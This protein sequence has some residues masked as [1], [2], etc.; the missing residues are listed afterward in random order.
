MGKVERRH[1]HIVDTGLAMLKHTGIEEQFWDY[2]FMTAVYLY[3][4]NPTSILGGISPYEALN[5]RAPEY[6]KLR[7]F[8]SICYPNMRP[9][10][11]NKLGDKSQQC[12]F[13]GYPAN[14]DG[15]ICMNM[16]DGRTILSRDVVFLENDFLSKK[17]L[18]SENTEQLDHSSDDEHEQEI[19]HTAGTETLV[20]SEKIPNNSF[21]IPDI[22]TYVRRKNVT[23][24]AEHPHAVSI[25]EHPIDA[26]D[27]QQAMADNLLNEE[28][29][30]VSSKSSSDEEYHPDESEE[31][32]KVVHIPV[33]R[34]VVKRGNPKYVLSITPTQ[35]IAPK[36]VKLA[37]AD[38][39]WKDAMQQEYDA[40]MRNE[41]WELI[42]KS[43]TDN[44]I[45]NI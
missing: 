27:E 17:D 3:N 39:E 12:V 21:S 45:N 15:Y 18:N 5:H 37:L 29:I 34:G 14:C 10:R 36:S 44:V 2:A 28:S 22:Q 33:T 40:L 24:P 42:P 1:R 7:V 16:E 4:R 20:R 9:Y 32:E 26:I 43:A 31:E 30:S 38:P 19:V 25:S 23:Q 35:K 8:G 6:F 11:E 41:T 13:M